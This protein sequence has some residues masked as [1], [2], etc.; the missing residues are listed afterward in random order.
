M[1]PKKLNFVQFIDDKRLG[2]ASQQ[3]TEF[4]NDVENAHLL[5]MSSSVMPM[6]VLLAGRNQSATYAVNSITVC[7]IQTDPQ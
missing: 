4:F 1:I 7:Y 6:S 3:M 5:E 2:S